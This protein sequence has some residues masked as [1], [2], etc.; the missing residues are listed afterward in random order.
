MYSI[1]QGR[2][3][4]HWSSSLKIMPSV[5][6]CNIHISCWFRLQLEPKTKTWSFGHCMKTSRNKS[7][8][9]KII[10]SALCLKMIYNKEAFVVPFS[11]TAFI[12]NNSSSLFKCESRVILTFLWYLE[13]S[14]SYWKKLFRHKG[15]ENTLNNFTQI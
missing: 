1:L 6:A 10:S 12:E 5:Y 8:I 7:L 11:R 9:F 4:A 3:V 2:N 13:F 15:R 14:H